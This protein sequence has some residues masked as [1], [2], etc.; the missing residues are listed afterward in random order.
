[1][2]EGNQPH[3]ALKDISADEWT[4]IYKKV[5]VG[6]IKYIQSKIGVVGPEKSLAGGMTFDDVVEEIMARVWKGKRRWDPEK[7]G[8]IETHMIRQAQSIINHDF[9]SASAKHDVSI[10]P[11]SGE[12]MDE[13]T[14]LE[15]L[16]LQEAI[17]TG[18]ALNT[19]EEVAI[20][21]ETSIE[22]NELFNK[23]MEIVMDS[24][25]EDLIAIIEAFTDPDIEGFKPRHIS[26]KLGVGIRT[27]ENNLKRLAR[28]VKRNLSSH[29]R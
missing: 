22:R 19:P 10:Q 26:K 18:K 13:A 2:S 4:V 7:N 20:D 14:L 29:S 24:G 16:L 8:A 25:D 9:N 6:V 5:K 3:L 15:S 17:K 12:D 28:F 1:M 11:T 23:V 27:Y 21:N